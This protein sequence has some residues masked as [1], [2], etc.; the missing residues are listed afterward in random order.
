MYRWTVALIVLSLGGC[1]VI[2]KAKDTID[3]LTNPLVG[4]GFVIGV[5][6]PE[7]DLIDLE[8]A[9]YEAGT[10]LTAF[11]ADAGS[12][13]DLENA[14][15]SG[16][17]LSLDGVAAAEETGGLYLINPTGGLD[18]ADNAQW[19][20]EVRATPDAEVSKATLTLPPG[21][22]LGISESQTPGQD[23]TLDF[24]GLGYDSALVVVLEA[25][26]GN[27]TFSNEPKG[28]KEVYDFTHGSE[29]LSTIVIPGATAFPN[30]TLYA[31]GVAPMVHTTNED[32][33]NMNTAL[34]KFLAGKMSFYPVSTAP[35]PEG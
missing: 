20:I 15:L 32:L 35:I 2:D 23:L 26:S 8:K 21:A 34:S 18:Y 29:E 19:P 3:G 9:G 17:T 33:E 7:S 10:T 1:D 24:T 28:I 12:V 22:D 13:T 6:A 27:I 30:E 16:A 11:L 14:P 31:V 4:L 25:E 5:E